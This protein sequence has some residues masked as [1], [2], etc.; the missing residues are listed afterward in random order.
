MHIWG[1]IEYTLLW[2]RGSDK[3]SSAGSG[4][5]SARSSVKV[6]WQEGRAVEI[7]R[8]RRLRHGLLLPCV[9]SSWWSPY[10][11]SMP[12]IP[13]ERLE[14]ANSSSSSSSTLNWGSFDSM[15]LVYVFKL[16]IMT[17]S[18]PF[19]TDGS[20]SRSGRRKPWSKPW[21]RSKQVRT[22]S[23]S[24]RGN[25][26]LAELLADHIISSFLRKTRSCLGPEL[27]DIHFI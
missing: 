25:C 11:L 1:V 9:Q 3:A 10:S 14:K 7:G 22:Y 24:E 19:S 20:G 27:F 13:S 8:C 4:T 2:S 17:A 23:R 5:L 18:C 26:N 21:R 16:R 6:P 15:D 12:S